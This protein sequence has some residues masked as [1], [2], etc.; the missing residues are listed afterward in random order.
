MLGGLNLVRR[1]KVTGAVA[2]H[3]KGAGEAMLR[4]CTFALK[5]LLRLRDNSLSSLLAI[6]ASYVQNP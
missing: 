2:R 4:V 5:L 6:T 1:G 3:I